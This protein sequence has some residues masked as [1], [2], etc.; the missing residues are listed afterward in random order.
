MARKIRVTI[1][2]FVLLTVAAGSWQAKVRTTSWKRALNVVVF[3]INADGKAET[4]A[5]IHSLDDKSFEPIRKFMRDEARHYGI[6]L[7]NPVDVYIGSRVE[8]MPPPPPI[9]GSVPEV[10]FWSLR[11]RFWAWRHGEHPILEPD[12]R[13][14]ALF[15]HSSTTQRLEHSV[16]LQKGLIG[17][18]RL[19]ATP[20]M[21]AENNII[22]THELLHTLGATDKYD[23]ATNQP[24][25]PAGYAEPDIRPLYPQQFSEI[26]GGRIPVSQVRSVPPQTLDAVLVGPQ[27]AAEIGWQ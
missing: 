12:V 3:P 17:I 8:A 23:L 21:S 20:H 9:G 4:D 5:Y 11:M 7:L 6:S 19:F 2:L 22:I 10:M 24:L 15:F 18:A 26:M 16:G 27:T 25:Y 14:Y 13:M 1:L